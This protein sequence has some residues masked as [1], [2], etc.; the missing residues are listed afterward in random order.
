MGVQTIEWNRWGSRDCSPAKVTRKLFES[1]HT[2]LSHQYGGHCA[3]AMS[4]GELA[5]ESPES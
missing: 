1:L 4:L 2:H 5:P 3:L